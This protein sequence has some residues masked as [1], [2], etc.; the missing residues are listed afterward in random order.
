MKVNE[1][2]TKARITA[3]YSPAIIY[4][5][6]G[7]G[8]ESGEFAEKINDIVGC[9]EIPLDIKNDIIKELGDC[10]WYLSNLA[11]DINFTLEEIAC[12][13]LEC[14]TDGLTFSSYQAM[15]SMNSKY[16][17]KSSLK[18]MGFVGRVLEDVKKMLRDDGE[19][20]TE[21]RRLNIAQNLSMCMLCI[22][23]LAE[24]L[25]FNFEDVALFNLEK[26]SSRMKRGVISGEGDNR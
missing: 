26:V 13:N 17:A 10:L 4:P 7:L 25:D 18:Y 1:Y 8:G 20:L 6:L 9:I 19:K 24:M 2:Q 22:S 23:N 16:Y 12:L 11:F 15:A 21:K 14:N 5:A 3:N